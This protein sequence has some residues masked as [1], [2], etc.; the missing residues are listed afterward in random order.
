MISLVKPEKGKKLEAM[1]INM[2]QTGRIIKQ[3]TEPELIDMLEQIEGV[4][5]KSSGIK[6]K[7]KG[8]F[9]SDDDD[10]DDLLNV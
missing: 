8:G 5:S 4:E 6:F 7:R 2:A 10:L 9:D 1:L 3:L